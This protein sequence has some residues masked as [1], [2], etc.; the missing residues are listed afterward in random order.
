MRQRYEARRSYR[1]DMR[2][3]AADLVRI[4]ADLEEPLTVSELADHVGAQRV[5]DIAVTVRAL[6]EDGALA[7]TPTLDGRRVL[8]V[9][10]AGW[11]RYLTR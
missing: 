11:E 1:F 3:G 8:T 5:P 6:V 2:Y 7:H 10:P 9:T 4:V